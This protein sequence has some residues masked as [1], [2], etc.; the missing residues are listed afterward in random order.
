MLKLLKKKDPKKELRAILGAYELPSFP[1]VILGA[2]EKA[3]DASAELSEISDLISADP[4][5]TVRLLTTVNS[6]AFALRHKVRSVHHAVSL[7]GR[8]R[9]ES[10]LISMAVRDSLPKG[11]RRGF[12]PRR[13]WTTSARRACVAAA[14]ADRIDPSTRSESFT[15]SLLQDMAV[16]VLSHRRQDEYGE[17][18]EHWHNGS[19]DMASLE[20]GRFGWDHAQVGQW[21][22][23]AWKFPEKLADSIALH[24][25]EDLDAQEVFPAVCLVASLREVNE[26]EGIERLVETT[27]AR[28]HVPKDETVEMLERSFA[29]AETIARLFV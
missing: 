11:A 4:G 10:M 9:L 29:D 24:H 1:G 7:L 6:P 21:M 8:S 13:F 12:E 16:P 23:A 5:F 28:Y 25:A 18:L 20:R 27:H 14:I 22:G 17:L 3:R 15:A 2:L 19:E 26:E